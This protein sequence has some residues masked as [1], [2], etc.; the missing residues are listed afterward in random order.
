[1]PHEECQLD[2]CVEARSLLRNLRYENEPLREEL[3]ILTAKVEKVKSK[4]DSTLQEIEFK[5]ASNQR[6]QKEM[7]DQSKLMEELRYSYEI[8]KRSNSELVLE[9]QHSIQQL[10]SLKKRE[11]AA[12]LA[13]QKLLDDAKNTVQFSPIR[14]MFKLPNEETLIVSALRATEED[15]IKSEDSY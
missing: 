14:P 11:A 13:I 6:F 8:G 12:Y 15:E 10:E 1:M 7:K 4:I 9:K 2:Q 3:S 5:K